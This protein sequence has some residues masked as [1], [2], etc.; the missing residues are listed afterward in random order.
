MKKIALSLHGYFNNKADPDSGNNGFK[1]LCETLLSK[2]EVDVFIHSWDTDKRDHIEALYSPLFSYFEDQIDFKEVM[3]FS[4]VSQE[5][6]DEGFDRN[7]SPYS[8]CQISSTLS[9][10]YSRKKSL[11][12][13]YMYEEENNFKYD[14]V[15]SARFDL[16]QRDKFGKWKYYVS[17]MNF[18]PELDM[19]FM[20]SAMWD[21]LNAGYADQWFYSNS[22][23][24]RLLSMAYD[25]ALYEYFKPGSDYEKNVTTGWPDSLEYDGSFYD[26]NQF[27]N[28]KLKPYRDL[29]NLVSEMKYPKWQCVNNHILY[30][31]FMIHYDLYE[32]SRFV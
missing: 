18:D 3:K 20:Y 25:A 22:N 23:N 24:M 1:Y 19:N 26:A 4:N 8:T 14:A 16:G 27:S 15:I 7:N 28:E 11:D 12:L 5:H 2:Y 13:V 21:Q 31:W 6:F 10:L 9:F 29:R 30:K 17:Q 32:K